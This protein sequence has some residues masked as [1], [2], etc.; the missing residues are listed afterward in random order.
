MIISPPMP[1]RA[2]MSEAEV[3]LRLACHLLDCGL[4]VSDVRVAIDGAQVKTGRTVHFSVTQ[5]LTKHGYR[6]TERGARWQGTYA[7]LGQRPSL[8]VH[9][10]PGEGDVVARL[11]GG[12]TLRVE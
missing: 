2:T 11:R 3:S 10:R 7:R 8:V 1:S 9:S 5:F 6:H 12:R 4:T